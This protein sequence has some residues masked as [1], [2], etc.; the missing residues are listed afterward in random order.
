ME[1]M[2]SEFYTAF[3]YKASLEYLDP[4]VKLLAKAQGTQY[5][6]MT[7]LGKESKKEW[8]YIFV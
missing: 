3:S 6:V 1:S 7:Y 2:A 4:G 8:P 5:S